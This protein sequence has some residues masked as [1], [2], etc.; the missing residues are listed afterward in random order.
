MVTHF[1][2]LDI[3]KY[4][5]KKLIW[6][7]PMFVPKEDLHHILMSIN[8]NH[9]KKRG[10][11]CE[12][13]NS[14]RNSQKCDLNIYSY[15]EWCWSHL[16][17]SRSH[18]NQL[19]PLLSLTILILII[20]QYVFQAYFETWCVTNYANSHLQQ[21]LTLLFPTQSFHLCLLL[22]KCQA[23]FNHCV[24]QS[25]T[26]FRCIISFF[27]TLLIVGRCDFTTCY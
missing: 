6:N 15:L 5:V 4:V 7:K 27:K 18:F 20:E 19:Q 8:M 25:L 16:E 2:H 17:S 24:W 10:L 3:S 23:P 9:F 21:M 12:R 1:F 13:L 22:Q 11:Q 14:W 26:H